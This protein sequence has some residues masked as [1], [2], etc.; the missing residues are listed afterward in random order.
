ME[1]TL[2]SDQYNAIIT[3]ISNV[4]SSVDGLV[5]LSNMDWFLYIM[6]GIIVSW[7]FI[8]GIRIVNS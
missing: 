4:Q 2:T 1:V 6:V 7:A 3:A 8:A 5:L